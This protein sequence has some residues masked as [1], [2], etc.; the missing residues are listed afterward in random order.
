MR[1]A[2]LSHAD[3]TP[4]GNTL[5]KA[6]STLPGSDMN[7]YSMQFWPLYF[8]RGSN[9]IRLFSNSKVGRMVKNLKTTSLKEALKK[10]GN[11]SI[12]K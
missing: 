10:L 6:D 11:V 8:Q 4:L 12:G 3:I 7:K 2:K 5:T 9:E 1:Y